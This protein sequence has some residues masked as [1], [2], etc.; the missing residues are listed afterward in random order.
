MAKP[1][2]EKD[3]HQNNRH[4]NYQKKQQN[5]T[6]QFTTKSRNSDDKWTFQG[7]TRVSEK[8]TEKIEKHQEDFIDY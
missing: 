5:K 8:T 7:Q 2:Q 4:K 1:V 6:E 3:N